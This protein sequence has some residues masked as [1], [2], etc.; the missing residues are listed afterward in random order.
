VTK[1]DGQSPTFD[2][3]PKPSP[4]CA[5]LTRLADRLEAENAVIRGRLEVHHVANPEPYTPDFLPVD[6]PHRAPK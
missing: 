6:P 1:W 2:D 3:P 4:L 5:E